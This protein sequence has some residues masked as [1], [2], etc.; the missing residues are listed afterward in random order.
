MAE[1]EYTRIEHEKPFKY[2]EDGLHVTRGSAWTA[3]GCHLGC[4][5]LMY[6]DDE[7][8]LV[9]VEGDPEHPYNAGRLCM[10]CLD[11]PEVVYNE[12]RI[13]HPM[14][15]AKEDRGKDAWE[16]I[17]WDEAFD[18][19]EERFN[20]YK[21][22][23]G[24]ESVM[25][26][27]GTG[28]DIASWITRLCWSFDSPNY[29]FGMSGMSCYAPRI[30]GLFATTGAF[31]LGDYSQQFALRYDDPR[32]EVPETIIIWGNNPIVS[33]SDGLYG[34]WVVD[35][36]KRG[37]KLIVM[38]PRATWL[39]SKA[40]YHLPIRPGTDG[41]M[42]LTMLNIII[43]EDLYD[44][45]F[46][47]RWCYGFDELAEACAEYTPERGE[48]ITWVPAEDIVAAARMWANGKNG[49][50][51]WGVAVDMTV[52]TLPTAQAICAL[53]QICGFVDKPGS[54]VAPVE[55]LNYAGGWGE[56][57][58]SP[59]QYDKRI[60]I[61]EY[62]L[63]RFG[64]KLCSTDMLI[65][66][67][68]TDDPYPLKAAWLQTTNTLANPSPDPERALKA[69]RRLDFIVAVDL[70]MTPTAMALAD[71]FLPA[72]MFPER[73]GI[74]VGDGFQRGETINQVIKTE[75]VKSDMEINL[76]MGKRFNPEAWPWDTVEEMFSHILEQS[77]YSFEQMQEIAPL[78]LPFEYNRYEKGLLRPDGQPG[79]N[80]ET[81]RIELWSNFY[82][83]VAHL[84]PLPIY[85]EPEPGPLSTPELYAEYPIV[86]T[87][88][89]RV[90]SFFHSEHRQ[91]PRLRA[92]RPWPIVELNQKTADKYGVCDGDWVWLENDR[93]RCK[94]MVEITPIVRDDVA[95]TD[96]AWWYPEAPGEMDDGL[97]GMWDLQVGNLIPYKAGKSGFGN[98]NK[99]TLCKIYK[100]K[101]GEHNVVE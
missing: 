97:Y 95:N 85:S 54:M 28:R 82:V 57:L 50:I 36:M 19:V 43:S 33:N 8:R 10:R 58:L 41:A 56:E 79:F 26:W 21:A 27:Q 81:G 60:G 4:G 48:E 99:S 22:H 5:V 93:D 34:H 91:I 46:V 13:L 98:S 42:A 37:S 18:L 67:M 89:A 15:R 73:N 80:T 101:E 61:K 40:E 92:L 74:R 6:T 1:R 90:W 70:F 11:L 52:E 44:H 78:Y 9:K 32:W 17:S 100:C 77:G 38:D 3:P 71:V 63:L 53:W 25:F 12:S 76:E 69:F 45:D 65:K 29:C 39:A 16:P 49:I 30:A 64:F 94:R 51:Q 86:L 62:P 68:E 75:G 35:C 55:L 96:H 47:D 59:E 23:Y 14:K 83:N 20:Y 88:G 7:G 2:D 84:D 72:A 87:T 24:A 31:W 66:V